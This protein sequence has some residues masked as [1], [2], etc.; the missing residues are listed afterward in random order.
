MLKMKCLTVKVAQNEIVRCVLR[1]G[2]PLAMDENDVTV[3][4]SAARGAYTARIEIDDDQLLVSKTT[5][6][7][8]VDNACRS[9][10][11]FFSSPL[12]TCAGLIRMSLAEHGVRAD[13]LPYTVH[14]VP[15]RFSCT[16]ADRRY[17]V[18]VS[19]LMPTQLAARTHAFKLLL[20]DFIDGR[21]HDLARH[22]VDVDGAKD[23]VLQVKRSEQQ[24]Q[25]A[26]RAGAD[27]AEED[28]AEDRRVAGA[29]A[30]AQ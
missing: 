17:G 22:D 25:R 20:C 14:G 13:E 23:H 26:G 7:E 24:C 4:I 28:V 19:D 3:H 15:G 30:P 27:G 2:A 5:L 18:F 1:N 10:D 6:P 29:P 21:R 11:A 16:L 9:V 12:V 8:L